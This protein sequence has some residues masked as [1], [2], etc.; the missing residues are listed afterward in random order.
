MG[1]FKQGKS[2]LINAL[3]NAPVCPIDDDVATSVPTAV[4]YAPE[5]SAYVIKRVGDGDDP[6]AKVERI[7]VP[8]E[9]LAEYVSE[10]GNPGNERKLVGAEVLIPREILKGGLR[11]VDSP[12]VGGIDS[13]T[14]LTTLSA[15]A[16]AHAVLVVSDA[17]QELT[18]PEVQLLKHAMR[19]S[20]NVAGV[21]AKTD[22][23]P[24]W[25]E[26]ER[27]DRRH[28]RHVGEMPLFPVSSD[29]RLLAASEQSREL[30]TESG[31]PSLVAHLRNDVLAKAEL[32][33]ARAAVHDLA[34]V[35]EQ[36]TV[37]LRSELSAI[38]HPEDTP[39]LIAE[40]EHAKARAEEFRSRTS[41]WQVALSDGMADLISDMEHDLRDLAAPGAAGGRTGDRRGRPRPHLGADLGVDRPAGR[42]GNLRD[43]RLDRRTLPLAYRRGGRAVRGRR[44]LA[45]P[46]RGGSTTASSTPKRRCPASTRAR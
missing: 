9:E 39:R 18:E 14:A 20:P 32:I 23:Y 3:V 24:D 12:G 27:I 5:P 4:G 37:S 46:D 13:S 38:L 15:L 45:A 34:F 40:L 29:L 1:E 41:K 2:K 6:A 19:I 21:L 7:P 44:D 11:L 33:N 10:H 25:R 8:M 35:T 30:N 28:L 36:M 31:F 17:S 16:S 43:V 26:I 42:R 22:L